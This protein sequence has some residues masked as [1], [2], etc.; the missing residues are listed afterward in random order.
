M[1][2]VITWPTINRAQETAPV[3]QASEVKGALLVQIMRQLRWPAEGEYQ[4]F[5]IAIWKDTTLHQDWQ[6]LNQLSV[7]GLPLQVSLVNSVEELDVVHLVYLPQQFNNDLAQIALSTRGKGVLTVGEN[8]EALHNIMINLVLEPSTAEGARLTFQINRPNIAYEGIE[9]M[10]ELVLFGGSEIDIAEL[11]FRTEQAISQL[12]EDNQASFRQLQQQ[13]QASLELQG[14]IN[15]LN[16]A[17]SARQGDLAAKEKSLQ[18]LAERE[19]S[20][21][22]QFEQARQQ[23]VLKEQ[24]IA[25]VEQEL[26]A[27]QNNVTSQRQI[28]DS[29]ETEIATTRQALMAQQEALS[30]SQKE[31]QSQSQLIDQQ[32][33]IILWVLAVAVV[34]VLAAFLI[35]YLFVKN[36]RVNRKLHIA[37]ENLTEAREQ[38]VESE[39]L[40]SLGQLVAGVAHEINTPIGIALTAVS[41]MGYDVKEF[42]EKLSEG[43][44]KKSEADTFAQ[45]MEQIDGLVQGNLERCARLIENFKLISADQVVAQNRRIALR[46]YCEKVMTTLSI[47]LKQNNVSWLVEGDNPEIDLDPGLLSQIITNLTTNAVNHAFN[48]EAEKQV[49][50]TITQLTDKTEFAFRDNGSGMGE[51][52]KQKLFEPFFTTKRGAG[53]LGLGLNIVYNLVASKLNGS[54]VV[55]SEVGKGT[56]FTI[57][58][59]C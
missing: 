39:K 34:F 30:R 48:D 1:L 23:A 41:T 18:Q 8:S 57:Q 9:V 42:K 31:V 25:Q 15:Q 12:R 51:E 40:A 26:Q 7:R 44:L 38:L 3:Y 29:L 22:Q 37:V 14:Q 49:T 32:R 27:Y 20:A 56:V 45:K 19:E 4:A 13:K 50:L 33:D 10:P 36:K 2:T 58:L 52:V 54:I 5:R 46:D 59:P 17:L 6:S 11:Y 55:E 24:Q 47:I 21:R 28:L 43:R 16:N 53:G 35:G